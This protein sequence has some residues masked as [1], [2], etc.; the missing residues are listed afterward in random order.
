MVKAS[1]DFP[2]KEKLAQAKKSLD[3]LCRSNHLDAA[4]QAERILRNIEVSNPSQMLNVTEYHRVLDLYIARNRV[5]RAHQL[6]LTMK[7]TPSNLGFAI[8]AQAWIQKRQL[9]KVEELLTFY[10]NRG[11]AGT[12][13]FNVLIAEY[14]SRGNFQPNQA[15]DLLHL[16]DAYARDGHLEAKPDKMTITSIL[17]ILATQGRPLEAEA[18][19]HRMFASSDPGMAPDAVAYSLVLKAYATCRMV[20][21][22]ER[23]HQLLE[24]MEER[25]RNR[26]KLA[27]KPNTVV[28]N[29]FLSVVA[30]AGDGERA[31]AVLKHM[32]MREDLEPDTISY[33]TVLTAWKN[34]GNGIRAEQLLW[35]VPHPDR[36]CF[37]IAIAA[38]A[39]QG[40]GKRA[41]AIL[42]YMYQDGRDE[43]RPN[44]KT[45]TAVL[46]AWAN[47]N[48]PDAFKNAKRHLYEMGKLA[49]VAID[50]AVF[51]AFLKAVENSS[52]PDKVNIVRY[53]L[54]RMKK[55]KPASPNS[56]TY[57]QAI[58]AIAATNGDTRVKQ[59]ALRAALQIYQDRTSLS[60]KEQKDIK[61]HTSMME[62]CRKLS[63]KGING[64]EIVEQVFLCCCKEG[65]VDSLFIM[66]LKEAASDELL[67]RIFN[68]DTLDREVFLRFPQSWSRMRNRG[69]R[70]GKR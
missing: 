20:D 14:A 11:I 47:S 34:A 2:S 22:P 36:P 50:T 31:E 60:A 5:D 65:V 53:V 12:M 24:I 70:K 61:I 67:K 51:N 9:S 44:T 6:L 40:E 54:Q 42:Y 37:S 35:R 62:A 13:C 68:T 52:E 30:N 39:K 16:M 41:E 66:L 25:Y 64:D 26:G 1:R 27:L 15:V 48:E 32:E 45:H 46:K 43:L 3:Q 29:A 4:E 18:L 10:M 17:Q 19:L 69:E 38:L 56:T 49:N 8:V 23:A 7:Q 57:R 33:G 58:K 21:A 63:P 28:Y 55:F 59:E